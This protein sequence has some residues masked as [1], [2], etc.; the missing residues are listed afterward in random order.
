MWRTLLS[1]NIDAH[2]TAHSRRPDGS[3]KL[4]EGE[5][6]HLRVGSNPALPAAVRPSTACMSAPVDTFRARAT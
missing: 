1:I 2:A 5:G 3:I 4:N 6:G